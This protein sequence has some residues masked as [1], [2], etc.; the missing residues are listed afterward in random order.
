MKAPK[1]H[2][3]IAMAVLTL[4]TLVVRASPAGRQ[5]H[6]W[7]VGRAFTASMIIAIAFWTGLALVLGSLGVWFALRARGMGA[8]TRAVT[9]AVLLNLAAAGLVLSTLR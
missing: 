6:D 3:S 9:L 5:F 7:L 8:S 2:R 1:C 4:M